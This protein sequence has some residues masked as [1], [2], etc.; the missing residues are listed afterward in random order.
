[1]RAISKKEL[2]G[3]MKQC[4]KCKEN[5]ERGIMIAI[6]K[7]T[8]FNKHLELCTKKKTDLN[9]PFWDLDREMAD[10]MERFERSWNETIQNYKDNPDSIKRQIEAWWC[11]RCAAKHGVDI[12]TIDAADMDKYFIVEE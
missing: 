10:Y 8:V 5:K 2:P 3:N 6:K 4:S 7:E 1:M 9:L 12:S 11:Q